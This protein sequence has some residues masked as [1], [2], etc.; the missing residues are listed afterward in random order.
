MRAFT[1]DLGVDG[2]GR[3]GGVEGEEVEEDGV[4][5]PS[6]EVVDLGRHRLDE[7]AGRDRLHGG[8]EDLVFPGLAT[9]VLTQTLLISL[10]VTRERA[11]NPRA[12]TFSPNRVPRRN[13][14]LPRS[15]SPPSFGCGPFAPTTSPTYHF[16][17]MKVTQALLALSSLVVTV[18]GEQPIP[19]PPHFA[20][21]A[22]APFVFSRP[23][24]TAHDEP[25][26][27]EE[28]A[29]Q[30][31]L[32]E[33]MYHCMPQIIKYNAA[34]KAAVSLQLAP[35]KRQFPGGGACALDGIPR[36][37]T[38]RAGGRARGR[39]PLVDLSSRRFWPMR[40]GAPA[41]LWAG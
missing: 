39:Q 35:E 29:H 41:A 3:S 6:E 8:D 27:P 38:G 22:R 34:R 18:S 31:H 25:K 9:G 37:D 19:P 32:Q 30:I 15:D 26:T 2:E 33:S 4:E 11:T 40:S 28:V 24:A 23:F 21:G 36:T 14:V 1:F 10:R 20:P 13:N 16:H 7:R 12:S 5:G 17:I